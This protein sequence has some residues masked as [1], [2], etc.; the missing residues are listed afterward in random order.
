MKIVDFFRKISNKIAVTAKESE[1]KATKEI[2]NSNKKYKTDD[3]LD[4]IPDSAAS[5]LF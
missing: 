3:L 5:A 2:T 4:E 1:V